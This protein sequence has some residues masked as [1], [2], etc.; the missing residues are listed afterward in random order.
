[1]LAVTHHLRLGC[2]QGLTFDEVSVISVGLKILAFGQN[3]W[4]DFPLI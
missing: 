1:M 3:F 4:F 2:D